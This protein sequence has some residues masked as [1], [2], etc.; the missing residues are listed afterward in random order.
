MK[1]GCAG[2]IFGVVCAWGIVVAPAL[3]QEDLD[4]VAAEQQ[5]NAK[6]QR[7][8]DMGMEP[9]AATFMALLSE[10]GMSPVEIMLM[11]MLS[12][13]GGDEAGGIMLLLNAMK[14]MAP[15]QPVAID[16]GQQLLVID[17]GVLYAIDLT[18]MAVTGTVAYA[19]KQG[20]DADA[21]WQL[22]AP[23]I[24]RAGRGERDE[25]VAGQC[26]QRM[27]AA[28]E[29]IARYVRDHDGALPGR[30]WATALAP[31]LAAPEL[32]RC[33]A[34]PE[35]AVG[36]A[37]N[38]K[39]V[40]AVLAEIAEPARTV[41]LFETVLDEANPIGGPE[42]VGLEGVHNGGVHVLFVSGETEW[43]SVAEARE[44]L[45]RPIGRE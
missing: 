8:I 6:V 21:I 19:Q 14:Q 34:R 15:S 10:S 30:E 24:A 40:G 28:G 43:V 33:P 22:L 18:T 17:R 7:F 26:R 3:G 29:A 41:L 38:E 4:R 36:Y 23:I 13:K 2:V 31:Y 25:G 16:R 20:A 5:V 42:G 39:L 12:E 1:R 37:M 9:E 32:L 27:R 44:L 35:V 11:M 45:A